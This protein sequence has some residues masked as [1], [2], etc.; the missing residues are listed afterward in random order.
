MGRSQQRVSGDK[1]QKL[2]NRTIRVIPKSDFYSSTSS[3]RGEQGSDNLYI[4]RK[5]QKLKLMFKTLN[6]QSP[7][8]GGGGVIFIGG[9]GYDLVG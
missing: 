2:P 8:G 9:L 1:L 7:G 4:R 3:L 6:D 5:K